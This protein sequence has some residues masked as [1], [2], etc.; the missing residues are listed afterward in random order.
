MPRVVSFEEIFNTLQT[1]FGTT[2]KNPHVES[3]WSITA[4]S[5]ALSMSYSATRDRIHAACS[6]GDQTHGYSSIFSYN[7][8]TSRIDPVCPHFLEHYPFVDPQADEAERYLEAYRL[9]WC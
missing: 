1:Y 4:T 9:L 6:E 7:P 3:P 8:K 5:Y 2:G